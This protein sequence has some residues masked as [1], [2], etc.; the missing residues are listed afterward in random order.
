MDKSL[1]KRI[2]SELNIF[3]GLEIMF[4]YIIK[5]KD[6]LEFIHWVNKRRTLKYA[7][8]RAKLGY[9]NDL[10]INC[11]HLKTQKV[12]EDRQLFMNYFCFKNKSLRVKDPYDWECNRFIHK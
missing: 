11:L 4:W 8:K 5:S 2:F 7:H 6:F 10:C 3:K 1:I 12:I 9:N